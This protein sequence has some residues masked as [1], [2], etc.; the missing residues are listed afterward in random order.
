MANLI[1]PHA[2][3]AVTREYWIRV[4]TVW[5][6]LVAAASMAVGML[7]LPT[8]VLIESQN[9]ALANRFED[10]RTAQEAYEEA[11]KMITAANEIAEYLDQ[12]STAAPFTVLVETIDTL[13]GDSVEVREYAFVGGSREAAPLVI[14]GMASNRTALADFRDA[15]RQNEHF[16]EVDLPLAN[17]AGE[18][19]IP[20][21]M[22]LTLQSE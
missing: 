18:R 20:F 7:M 8:Y 6:F 15:L 11:S 16:T 12:T 2:K 21:R 14:S 17:L 3:K 10:A 1:P 9:E 4:G 19:D 13:A 22:Q 5:M